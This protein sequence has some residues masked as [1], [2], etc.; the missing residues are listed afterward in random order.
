MTY[1]INMNTFAGITITIKPT[2]KDFGFF[3]ELYQSNNIFLIT[4]TVS[5]EWKNQ[6]V[7]AIQCNLMVE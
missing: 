6:L 3:L 1:M 5:A 2:M 4:V 7:M